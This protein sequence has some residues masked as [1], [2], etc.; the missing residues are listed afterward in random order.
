[1]GNDGKTFNLE[2]L[3]AIIRLL[4]PDR[5]GSLSLLDFVKS[6]DGVYKEMKLLRASIKNSEYIDRAFEKAFNVVFYGVMA[7]IILSRIGINPIALFV[8]LSGLILGFAFMIGSAASKMFE[9]FLFILI[10]RPYNIGDRIHISS[11]ESDTDPTGSAGWIVKDVTLFNTT[12]IYG[13]TGERATVANGSLAATRVINMARSPKATISV[14]LKILADAP[15]ERVKVFEQ[16]L[17][18]FIKARPR[19]WANFNGFRAG[20][21]H[22]DLGY[23]EYTVSLSHREAWQNIIAIINSKAEVAAFCLELTK[24]LELGVNTPNVPVTLT[25]AKDKNTDSEAGKFIRSFAGTGRVEELDVDAA[26]E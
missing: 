16:S 3:E 21:I 22:T 5:D 19:E 8:S 24:Q 2:K 14:P 11:V 25:W 4:R 18:D 17:R 20:T 15:F 26:D 10:R 7:C 9:G 13:A 23:I 12:L 1:M 6:A